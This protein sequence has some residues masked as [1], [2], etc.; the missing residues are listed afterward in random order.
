MTEVEKLEQQKELFK[1]QIEARNGLRRL[2]K[3]KDFKKYILEGFCEKQ[4]LEYLEAS[5]DFS[6]NEDNRNDALAIAKASTY[7]KRWFGVIEQMGNVAENNYLELDRAIDEA[8]SEEVE[9][10]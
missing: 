9:E 2:M 8:R 6:L 7:L 5:T 4:A 3:N 10:A 1:E